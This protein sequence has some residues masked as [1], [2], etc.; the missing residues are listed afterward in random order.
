MAPSSKFDIPHNSSMDE[1]AIAEIVALVKHS[2]H[3]RTVVA[4]ADWGIIEQ[5][6]EAAIEHA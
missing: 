3:Q 4:C 2:E 5:E 6:Q 1:D